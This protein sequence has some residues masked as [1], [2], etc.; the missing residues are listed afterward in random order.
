MIFKRIGIIGVGLIGG[1]IAKTIRR[2]QLPIHI[3]A[4]DPNV[5]LL[6]DAKLK[7]VIDELYPTIDHHLSTMDLIFLCA[8]VKHNNTLLQQVKTY[9]DK[10]T[11]LT[12][13]GSVKGMIHHAVSSLQLEA[14][15][16]GGHPM[17]GSEK[18]G[19]EASSD[20]L[21]ENAYYILT[22]CQGVADEKIEA[23]YKFVETLGAL[24]MLLDATQHDYATAAISHVPHILASSLVNLVASMDDTGLLKQL[25]A[26]GFKD[27]TRIASSS[28]NLWQQI[29]LY[30]KDKIQIIL[31]QYIRLLETFSKSLESENQE[32]IES[33]FDSA[34]SFRSSFSEPSLGLIKRTFEI[35][36]DIPDELGVIAKIASLLSGHH[37]N[38]K[39]LSIVN[40]REFDQGVLKIVFYDERSQSKS[41]ELLEA[42]NYTIT[43]S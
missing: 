20:H 27:I 32:A 29:S 14:Q 37:I 21:F 3:T 4:F 38:I 30:N 31:N 1:S 15:F 36:V 43:Q 2:K 23:Y 22:P 11:L 9:L 16:I 39:N 7:G 12:D 6:E 13:V 17:A 8:P 28:P 25:A 35:S 18:S 34:K 24:P 19:Y 40:H 26:G 10:E 33:F 41:V 5:S 42:N